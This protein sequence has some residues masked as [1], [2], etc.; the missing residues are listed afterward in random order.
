MENSSNTNTKEFNARKQICMNV[1]AENNNSEKISFISNKNRQN[2]LNHYR[3]SNSKLF[4]EIGVDKQEYFELNK[5]I[6]HYISLEDFT[7]TRDYINYKK[8]CNDIRM[9]QV[10]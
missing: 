7:Q 2:I 10:A 6:S 5:D 1:G 8:A 9:Q 3:D 4:E